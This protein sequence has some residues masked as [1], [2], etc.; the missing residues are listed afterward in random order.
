VLAAEAG[1]EVD[2]GA[3]RLAATPFPLSYTGRALPRW[4][5]RIGYTHW[6]VAGGGS[7]GYTTSARLSW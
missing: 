7:D 5:F 2:V 3:R 4:L 6:W 1:I